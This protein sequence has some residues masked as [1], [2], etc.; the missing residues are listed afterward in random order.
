[1]S[2][3]GFYSI[4]WLKWTPEM[5]IIMDSSADYFSPLIDLWFGTTLK[6]VMNT[7][8]QGSRWRPHNAYFVP[9]VM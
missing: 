1:M 7:V 4:S 8:T 6:I 5:I 9:G 2:K 3:A